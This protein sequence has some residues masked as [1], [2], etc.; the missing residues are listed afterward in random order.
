MRRHSG[1]R[2]KRANPESRSFENKFLK[3][4]SG[5][6]VRASALARAPR[7]DGAFKP[8]NPPPRRRA[9]EI[10]TASPAA[11][12]RCR[13]R[14]RLLR[15]AW[16]SAPDRA[17][18]RPAPDS[19]AGSM[20][21]AS[22]SPISKNSSA[23]SSRVEPIVGDDAVAAGFDPHQPGFGPFLGRDGVANRRRGRSGHARRGRCRHIPGRANTPDCAGIPRRVG[24]GWRSRRPAGRPA[25]RPPASRRR[26]RAPVS[27]SGVGSLPAACRPKN[28][29]SGSMVS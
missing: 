13:P 26:A 21:S 9:P 6:R 24:R 7:N 17:R 22:R 19:A 25:R 11:C 14:W 18:A 4:T 1:A 23:R 8:P 20:P 27:S 3:T 10:R 12:R 15:A 5:F 2:A 28:G 29:V 16:R